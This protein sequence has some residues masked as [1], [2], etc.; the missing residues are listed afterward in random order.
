MSGGGTV[1]YGGKVNAETQ[2]IID[3]CIEGYS[4]CEQSMS[5]CLNQGGQFVDMAIMGPL[6]DCADI[7]RTCAD[8]MMRQSPLSPEMATMC[9]R[10]ADMAGEACTKLGNDSTMKHCADVCRSCGEACRSL[11]GVRA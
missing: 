11:S 8:M 2:K 6:M 4:C 1:N 10:V 9:A 3:A 5:H 7:A